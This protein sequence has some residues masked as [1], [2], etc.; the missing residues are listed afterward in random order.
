METSLILLAEEVSENSQSPQQRLEFLVNAGPMVLFTC[1]AAGEFR[2]TFV[3]EGVRT[4]WGYEPEEFL[5]RSGFWS[6]RIHPED[7]ERFRNNLDVLLERGR[8]GHEYRF[9]AKNGEYRW[10]HDELRV[11][12]DSAGKPKE[13]VGHCVDI[14]ERKR[15][16]AALR[17]SEARLALIFNSTSDLQVLFRVEPDNRLVTETIN[18][19]Y[20][21]NFKA[22]TG[23]D[24][25]DFV[26]RDV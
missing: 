4:L 6:S 7:T 14:T 20:I 3:S 21:E 24:A 23:K 22:N 2:A 9:R 13:I 12:R 16:E 8:H 26:G 19:A 11:V 25:M 15:A 1:E 5:N 10:M 17:E 18:R